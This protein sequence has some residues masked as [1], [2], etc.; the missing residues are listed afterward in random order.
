MEV[1]ILWWHAVDSAL[2]DSESAE[3][4]QR[5]AANTVWKVGAVHQLA[6]HAPLAMGLVC[7]DDLDVD[8][9]GPKPHPGDLSGYEPHGVGEYSFDH[10]RDRRQ[11]CTKIDQ[12]TKQHVPSHPCARVDPRM[13]RARGLRL[14]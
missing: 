4:A 11:V 10:R 12:R 13:S 7:S 8:L 5:G 1:H 6:D 9:A 2:G 14:V 3:D